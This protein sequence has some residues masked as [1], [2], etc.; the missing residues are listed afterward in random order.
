[1]GSRFR[2]FYNIYQLY[3]LD[4]TIGFLLS[5][6]VFVVGLLLLVVFNKVYVKYYDIRFKSWEFVLRVVPVMVLVCIGVASF[7][8]LFYRGLVVNGGRFGDSFFGPV[9]DVKVV[10]HQWY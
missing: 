10:G 5:V 7:H 4:I 3:L 6:L 9:L 1:M 8:L 2:S